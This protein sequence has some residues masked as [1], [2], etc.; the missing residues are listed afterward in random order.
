MKVKIDVDGC[1]VLLSS[2]K[3]RKRVAFPDAWDGSELVPRSTISLLGGQC[4][5]LVNILDMRSND[6][7][8]GM[9]ILLM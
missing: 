2:L 7:F 8:P 5:V 9:G 1:K 3:L 4:L 6:L